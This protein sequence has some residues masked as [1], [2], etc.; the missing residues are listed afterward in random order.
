MGMARVRK[1][2]PVTNGKKQR[3]TARLRVDGQPQIST[4]GAYKSHVS[5]YSQT[6]MDIVRSPTLVTT[7]VGPFSPQITKR[8]KTS[9]PSREH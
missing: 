9:S 6:Y 7:Y 8:C 5:F 2:G 3:L 1:L 4:A